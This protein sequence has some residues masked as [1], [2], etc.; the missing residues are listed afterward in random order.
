M[1]TVSSE[2]P[3]EFDPSIYRERYTDV[4]HLSNDDLTAHFAAHGIHEGRCASA[5]EGR[6]DFFSLISSSLNALEIGPFNNPSIT[7]SRVKYFDTLSTDD[8]KKRAQEIGIDQ[9][10]IPEIHWIDPD[11]DLTV[12][13]ELFD[14]C[15]SSHAIEHQPDLVRHLINV[16][17]LLSPGGRYFLAVP[18]RRYTFD[19]FLKDSNVAEVIEAHRESRQ[20]HTLHSVIEHRALTTHNDPAAHW[21]GT[22]GDGEIDASKIQSAITEFEETDGYLDV[23]AWIFTPSSFRTIMTALFSLG[24]TQLTVERVYPTR[25]G[26]NEFY[27]ILRK[28]RFN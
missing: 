28:Q 9:S 18:D 24:L 2:F 6:T 1:G 22:H 5:I 19:H 8:L 25:R 20:R 16:A 26:S 11:G 14:C 27:V 15:V 10:N 7:S 21:N 4:N 17:G 12:V 13:K 3:L 23:H